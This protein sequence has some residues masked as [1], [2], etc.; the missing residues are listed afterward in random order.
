M[1]PIRI[2]F[3]TLLLAFV[4]NTLTLF[5]QTGPGGV[6]DITNTQLWLRADRGVFI[7]LPSIVYKWEDQSG[8]NRDFEPVITDQAVPTRSLNAL[9]GLPVITF[10]DNG[11]TDGE[12]LGYDGGLGFSGSDASTVFI[13]ARNTSAADEQNGGLYIGQKDVGAA[14]QVRNYSLEYDDAVRFNGES[15]VF[16]DGHTAGDWSMIVYSNQSGAAVSAYGAWLNGTALTGNS[17]SGTV[18]SLNASFTL[19][20][21]TQYGGTLNSEGF[22]DGDI[23]EVVVYSSRL[24]DA[25]RVV[26]ENSLAAKYN[27]SISNDHYAYQAA[28]SHDVSGI[29]GYNGT[30]FTNGFS[31]RILSINSPTNLSDNEYLFYGH[32]NG[33]ATAWTTTD[34][35][36]SSTY[37]LAREWRIDE[38]SDV[39]TVTVSIPA[40]SLPALPAGYNN[41][42]V[43]TD[44]DGNFSSGAT[45][46]LTTLTAG[47]YNVNLNLTAGQYLAIIVYR[48]EINFS[49]ASTSGAESVTNITVNANQNYSFPSDI[50]VDYAVTGGTATSGTDYSLPAGTMTITSGTTTGSFSFTV[51]ND[52]VV[53]ADETIIVGLSN[54]SPGVTIGPQG[55]YTY[56]ILNDDIVYASLS[57][58]TASEAEGNAAHAVGSPQITVS[59]GILESPASLVLTVTNG[60][61]SSSDWT[62]TVS[63][64]TIPAGNYSAPV[65]IAIPSAALSIAGD[66]TVENDETINLNINTFSG[67]NAGATVGCV[68]TIL[69]DDNATISVSTS[70]PIVVEGGPAAAGSGSFTFALSNPSAIARTVSYTVTGTA[71]SGTDFTALAGSFSFPANTVTYDVTLNAIADLLVEGDETV[72]VTISSIT[73]SPAISVDATPATITLDD[74]DLPV[75]NYTPASITMTEGTSTTVEVWLANPPVGTVVLNLSTAIPGELTLSPVTLTFNTANYA[76]HQVVNVQSVEDNMMGDNSDNIIITVNDAMSDDPFDPLADINIP[77]NITNNDIADLVVT[78]GSVTVAENGTV[79]FSVTLSAGPSSGNVVI[80]LNSGNLSVATIDKTSLTFNSGNWNVPQIVTVTGVNNF[81]IPNTNTT[82]NLAVNNALSNNDFDGLWETVAVTVTNDDTPGFTVNPVTLNINEGGPAGSF[83][84]VLT[85]QPVGSVVFDLLNTAPVHVTTVGQVTFTNANWN[86]P[87]TVNVTAVEDAL[88]ADRTDQIAVTVNQALTDNDFDSMTAQNVNITIQDND[89]PVITG[90]PADITRNN[91]PGTCGAVVTWTAPTSTAPMVSDHTPGETFPVGTTTVTYTST[92]EDMMVSYCIFD[93]TVN[94]TQT[95]TITCPANMANVPANAG[96]CYAT[97]ITLGTPLTGDNCG[98]ASVS[99]NAPA[100]FPVGTTNVV[101]T[102]TDNAGLTAS[103]TQVVIVV[104]TQAPTITCPPNLTGIPAGAGTCYAT[105]ISLGTPAT[106]DNCAVASV[107]NNAPAQFNTGITNVVWTVTDNAGLT[108]TCTQTVEVVDTQA[109]TITCP[110]DLASVSAD[111]G[112]CFAT[113]VALGTPT[114]TDN[115]STVTVTNNAP[116]Q[117]PLGTTVV[118]WTATDSEGLTATCTQNVT[119]VDNQPPAISCPPAVTGVPA[120]PG[121]CYATG[122]ILGSPVTSD[123]CGVASVTND[124]PAQYPV[125]N[126]TVTWT[127][128]DDGGLTSSCSQTVT[129]VDT[130]VPTISCP[131]NLTNIPTSPG[132][133]YATGISLGAP[134]TNDNCGV[135][136]VTNN[137]PAQ[138]PVG[139]TTV[140][141]TVTDNAGLTATCSQTVQVVDLQ[142]P[143]ITCPPNINNRPA[144]P[145]Q[146]YATGINLGT[147][148]VTDNCGTVASVTNDAPLQF[149]VGVTIVTWTATDGGGNVATCQQ[150]VRVV[151]TQVPMIVCPGSL[152]NIP[153]DPGQC[154]ATGVTLGTPFTSD[155]CGVQSL[156]N[157]A[158]AQF[159]V[160]STTVTWTVTD[161]T[162]FIATCV[163]TVQVVDAQA[164]S[165][166]CP[167]DLT[168]VPVNPGLCYATGVA[169]GSPVAIDNCNVASVTNNAPAQYPLGLTTVTWTVT[170]TRGLTATCV[171]SVTVVDN[172]APV[173]TCPSN[174]TGVA[175]NPGQCYAT[176]VGLGTPITSDNCSVASVTND[177]PVQFPIGTTTVTWTVTDVAGLTATCTQTVTV[178]DSQPPSITCPPD[179]TGISANAGLCYATGVA[180]GSPTTSD[181]CGSVTVTNNAPVQYPVGTTTVTWTATDSGGLTSTCLQRVIVVDDQPPTITCPADVTGITSDPGQ[182]YASGV[183][184]GTPLTADNCG[185][186]SVANDA[187]VNFPIGVTTVTWTVTDN[188]G[189][190]ATCTQTV[191]VT[192]TEP[193]VIAC[194]ADLAGIPADPGICTASGVTLG[195]PVTSDNCLIASVTNDAPAVFPIGVTTVTWTVT[196]NAGLSSTC[197]QTVEVVD[198]QAPVIT[199]CPPDQINI[200]A[201]INQCYSTNV[202]LFPPAATDN[203]G[204]GSITSDAPLQFPVG[205]TTVTWTVT[206]VN[207][208]TSSC[209]H[210][211]QVVDTQS[212]FLICPADI[213]DVADP[214]VCGAIVTWPDPFNT[215]N[216]PGQTISSNYLSGDLIPV[217]TSTVTYIATDASGNT[218]N[219]SFNIIITDTELPVLVTQDITAY[220]DAA[221]QVTI[222]PEDVIQS[223]TDNC[224]GSTAT[225]SQSVFTCADLGANNVTV[226][227]TD[228][229]G[230]SVTG[231]AIVTVADNIAPVVACTPATVYLD[232]TGNASLTAADV[233]AAPVTDN[234]SV[235]SVTLSRSAFTCADL[236]TVTVTLT[237]TDAGGNAASCDALVTVADTF[238]ISVYAGPDATICETDPSFAITLATDYNTTVVWSTSGTGTFDDP[239]LLNPVYTPATGDAPVITLT[240]TGTKVNGCPATVTDEMTLTLAGLPVADAGPDMDICLGTADIALI[241]AVAANGTILWTT[242]G[243][244]TFNDPTLANPVYT[245]GPSDNISVTLTVTVTNGGLCPD[246]TDD[247]TFTFTPAPE[248]N[249]GDNVSLCRTEPGYQITGASHANGIVTWTTTGNGTFDDITIDNPYYTFGSFDYSL[250]SVTLTMEVL[251]GGTCGIVDSAIVVTINPLPGIQ[252][253]N[254]ANV[255][256]TGLNDGEITLDANVGQAPFSFSIDGSPFQPSGIFTGLAPASYYFEVMDSFG[257]LSDTTLTIIDPLPFTMVVDTVEH[258]IC[259]GSNTGAIRI[260]PSG[261]TTPYNVSWTG[262]DGFTATTA[263]ITNLYAGSYS[264]VIS[265]LNNCATYTLDTLLTEPP[266][267]EVTSAVLSD[268]SGSGVSCNG[269]SDGS[270]TLTV[271]GGTGPLTFLWAGPDGF[272]ATAEDLTDL[273]AG[274]YDLTVTDSLGCNID[275]SYTLDNP[276]PIVITFGQESAS[277]PNIPDGSIDITVT[278]GTGTLA[279]LWEDNVTTEDRPEITGGDHLVTVTDANG[280]TETMTITVDMTLYNCLRVYEIITPN[281]DGRNDTWKMDYIELYPDAEVFVYTRWGKLVYH[282]R[283]VAAEPWDGTYEGKLLPN[284]SYHYVINLNDGTPSRTGVISIISK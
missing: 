188:S 21:A 39:G 208:V 226:T 43:V 282:S 225:V 236:G 51:V 63:T 111:A 211:V 140:V 184:L 124:A 178:V 87:V 120:N 115:C 134:V 284:D 204:I 42:A 143:T 187:P 238:N 118:I 165:I 255:S 279:F 84:I 59:G 44:T 62:Q 154:Y 164:P 88:D 100:Q 177:A 129:V 135:A 278:G 221:G 157:N 147:P 106:A 247:V 160:G 181:N 8:Q 276:E 180:L 148:S 28:H 73:G 50:T 196:D 9:N 275:V 230:N 55:T 172:E 11:G 16:D 158:P 205:T 128:T 130:Q 53:E 66:V 174:L 67:I 155:N 162:G 79:T 272:V 214:G 212:P 32:D 47:T 91:D 269:I 121:L 46:Y 38:T 64:I 23:A 69:N 122:V 246:D 57:S 201:D 264:L 98:V 78:P 199:S 153:A 233:L 251:G 159:P 35:P 193:P 169:L 105:G 33:V 273:A 202:I 274:T 267:I 108:A 182:C 97:G 262:P 127:V 265:D 10:N 220:L 144:D 210:T 186:A 101:W 156:T 170:D 30:T 203:C 109:P 137:A 85:A 176:G 229:S 179:L 173:I 1:K 94:D 271:T 86:I 34:V 31:S 257:C 18:P 3:I 268:Y 141:W 145:Y 217:G 82:I 49:V 213:T 75:I 259:A 249:A 104:D 13:V 54:A 277:C 222:L 194:P 232:V 218:S 123:N 114:A 239:T 19:L 258:V 48:L 2:L 22:F 60:T 195:T 190:T 7:I 133:C 5:S 231:V 36:A 89:P 80:D 52:A 138:F 163:Q 228:P 200:P 263:T 242:S 92:D 4:L 113:S 235:P 119:V 254:F 139:V 168:S 103:C 146:C 136:S 234:C 56:T 192:D 253:T 81:I 61:A 17:A 112:S 40:S 26:V 223:L 224:A 161:V 152:V 131:A 14:N 68:Y 99:N 166:A 197:Q 266:A 209:T 191:D 96:L 41:V 261:G 6:G 189:L 270:I 58:A 142:G 215:D 167:G 283:N 125:G 70:T 237:A 250:G 71:T 206:D 252:V 90:C 171:Q 29:A 20:G 150:T 260:T 25:S 240:I 281:G 227:A 83:T 280:C 149:P 198:D 45:A 183:S 245:F 74:D 175:P 243:D 77:V 241:D 248:A 219:C 24:N 95:P 102:V 76:T 117:F 37:R 216:C 132:L 116:V 256:C 27:L 185:I 93:V 65:S 207:G 12:F 110:A 126:T 151:D 15:Q 72:R 244:G 107:T